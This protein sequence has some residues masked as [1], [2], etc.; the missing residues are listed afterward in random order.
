VQ[1]A[2]LGTGQGVEL[3]NGNIELTPAAG[4]FKL[5]GSGHKG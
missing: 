1:P 2:V 4:R 5:I 3:N